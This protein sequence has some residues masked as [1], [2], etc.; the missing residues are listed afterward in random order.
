MLH[1]IQ[2]K[3]MKDFSFSL[4]GRKIVQLILKYNFFESSVIKYDLSLDFTPTRKCE[5]II[6]L[7]LVHI[8]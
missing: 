3:F 8:F 5:K 6:T 2:A 1:D 7:I 4:I